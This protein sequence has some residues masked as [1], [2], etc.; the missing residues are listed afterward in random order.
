M[1]WG[2]EQA[3]KLKLPCFLFASEYASG[4]K[5]YHNH[6]FKDIATGRWNHDSKMFPS[7]PEARATAMYRPVPG[8][9]GDE[10]RGKWM[11]EPL[12]RGEDGRMYILA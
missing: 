9:E 10:S 7:L 8:E 11:G 2:T 5:F 3:D 12:S 6:G 1:R 4:Q